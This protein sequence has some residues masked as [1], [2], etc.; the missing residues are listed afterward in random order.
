[1]HGTRFF[2]KIALS[3]FMVIISVALLLLLVLVRFPYSRTELAAIEEQGTFSTP[4]QTLFLTD[5]VH[6]AS[7]TSFYYLWKTSDG[8]LY[9]STATRFPFWKS[10]D[11]S[12]P[13]T[14]QQAELYQHSD[15]F[16]KVTLSYHE[17][18]LSLDE[19]TQLSFSVLAL[20][21]AFLVLL[22]N[23]FAACKE[24]KRRAQ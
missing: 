12:K 3:T 24:K 1:M 9:L 19:E 7:E 22:W 13:V 8:D 23:F 18:E 10:Y 20:P 15:F 11:L 2:P 6:T 21:F 4:A 14:F 16:H 5:S 17:N